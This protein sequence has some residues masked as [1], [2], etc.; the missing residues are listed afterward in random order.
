MAQKKITDLTLR[1]DFDATVN[2]PGDDTSQTWRVTGQQIQDFITSKKTLG[3][4]IENLTLATSV[5]GNALTVAVKTKANANASS[6]DPISVS[7]RSSTLTSGLYNLRQIT[8]ALSVV[9]SSGSTLGQ[10]SAQPANIYVYLIDNSGTLELAVSHKLYPEDSLVTTTAEGGA[11]A[12]DSATA[13]YSTTARA[14]VPCRLIGVILNT[15]TTAGTWA[16]A[17]TK[18]QLEPNKSFM[19]PTVQKFTSGSGTYN[20]PAGVKYLKVRMIGGGGGGGGGS[21]VAAS[22]GGAGGTGGTTTFGSSF[23]TCTG[24]AGGAGASSNDLRGGA[25]GTATMNSPAIGTSMSGGTGCS[26]NQFVTNGS[27]ASGTS[28]QGAGSPFA[29]GGMGGCAG[30]N[31]TAGQAPPANSGAGGGGGASTS[32]S[33]ANGGSGGGAGAFIDCL[34]PDPDSSYAYA[35]GGVGTAGTAGTGGNAGGAGAAGYIEVTEY[36]N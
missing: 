18:L 32:A 14:S 36:Y 7:M 5:S 4:Q 8:G 11:G 28:G 9:V 12:A 24:G 6:T 25:G 13:I 21:T 35:I 30:G 33:Y 27:G 1:S 17:G 2:L 20:K 26:S 34:I 23:L 16:S 22:N 31:V 19:C 15:Q 10:T 29:G 3:N